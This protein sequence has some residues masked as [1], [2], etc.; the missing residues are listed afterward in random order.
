MVHTGSRGEDVSVVDESPP[1]PLVPLL[2]VL[3]VD[4]ESC[5]G[6]VPGPG[7]ASSH[8]PPGSGGSTQPAGW[9]TEALSRVLRASNIKYSFNP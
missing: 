4:D 2:P 7:P 3:L 8:H 6:E 5:P 1:T 9:G